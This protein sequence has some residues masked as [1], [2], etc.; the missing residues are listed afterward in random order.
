M[1]LINNFEQLA[2]S[3]GRRVVLEVMEAGLSAI[4][5]AEVLDQGLSLNENKLVIAGQNFD[6]EKYDR[7]F[8]LGFGKGAAGISIIIDEKLGNRL[9]EGWVID[10]NENASTHNVDK[11]KYF[12]GTHPL[13]SEQN[14]EFTKNVVSKLEGKLT[15]KDLVLVVICGGGSA[16]LT[17][18]NCTIEELVETN[19][20]LLRSGATISEMN[21]VRKKIDRVKSGGLAKIL[22]PATV[23]SLIFSDVPGNS[24]SE[25]A[26]GP[27][28]LDAT[29]VEGANV[30]NILILSNLT[31]IQA[32]GRRAQELG[33][34]VTVHSDRLQGEARDVGAK[35]IKL[36]SE[37]GKHQIVLAGGETTVTVRGN[38]K[39]GRNQELVLGALSEMVSQ[40]VVGIN[41]LEQLRPHSGKEL[42]EPEADLQ[43]VVIASF[44]SDGWDNSL[45]AGAIGDIQTIQKSKQSDLELKKFLEN[46][47]AFSFFEKVEDGIETGRL[48]CNVSDLMIVLK[49]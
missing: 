39:G 22:F 8:L 16:L 34:Q 9:T 17:L 13:P 7:V 33:Y 6:L 11:T 28:V 43:G 31:A 2:M 20:K 27:T 24:L 10:V 15:E 23:A 47:D 19:K 35:L 21:A 38:G 25:I 41:Q 12:Q 37:S 40:S 49:S 46:N 26:S 32:M 44:D 5:P 30:H 3:E 4:Q 48:P 36:I 29:A 1:G 14:V 18:P 42:N 45:L